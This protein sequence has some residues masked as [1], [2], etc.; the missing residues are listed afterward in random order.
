MAVAARGAFR[1]TK[2][3]DFL[4]DWPLN[5]GHKLAQALSENGLPSTFHKGLGDDPVA[6]VIRT[7]VSTLSSTAHCDVLFPTKMWQLQ[8]IARATRVEM[9]GFILP[10]AQ[11][12]DLF[13]LK[14]YAGGPQDLLDAANL[15]ELQSEKERGVWKERAAKIGRSKMFARCL[16]FLARGE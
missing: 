15:Y 13:L 3:L 5:E 8:V 9:G 4:I 6:G 12:D 14:L 10:V 2:D 16:S 7:A 1:T 11:A